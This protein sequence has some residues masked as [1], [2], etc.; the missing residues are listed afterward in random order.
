MNIDNLLILISLLGL[1]VIITLLYFKALN[2]YTRKL[3]S[4]NMGREDKEIMSKSG[5]PLPSHPYHV[6]DPSP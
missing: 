4:I 3:W 1:L 2:D 5:I 6:V